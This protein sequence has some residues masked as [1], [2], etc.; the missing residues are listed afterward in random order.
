M[1]DPSQP[2]APVVAHQEADTLVATEQGYLA[3]NNNTGEFS[4]RFP[5]FPR[6]SRSNAESPLFCLIA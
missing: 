1:S 6:L 5:L 4:Q 3:V 2:A